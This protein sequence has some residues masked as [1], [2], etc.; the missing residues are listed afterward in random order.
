MEFYVNVLND[1][2][3]LP[4]E[5]PSIGIIICKSKNRTIVEYALKDTQKPIGV[6]TYNLTTTLPEAYKEKL[7]SAEE[8]ASKLDAFIELSKEQKP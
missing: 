5:N 7:P 4:H 1:S 2:V 3:K 8:L 6:E